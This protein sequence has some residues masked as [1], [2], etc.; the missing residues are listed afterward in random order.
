MKSPASFFLKV[1]VF[2]VRGHA[3]TQPRL[4]SPLTSMLYYGSAKEVQPPMNE[5]QSMREALL[6][7]G[8][9]EDKVEAYMAAVE[10]AEPRD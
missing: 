8:M 2:S 9:T 10:A 6:A 4:H 5:N 7:T 1:S 3:N